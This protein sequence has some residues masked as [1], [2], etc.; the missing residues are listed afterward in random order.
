MV[1]AQA[2][3]EQA[4]YAVQHGLSQQRAC[5]LMRAARSGL[6]YDLRMPVKDVPVVE[7]MIDLSW[8]FPRFGARRINVFLSRQGMKISKD[9][10]WSAAG[11]QVPP[12]KKRGRDVARTSP[13]PMSPLGGN[14]VWCFDFVRAPLWPVEFS[15]TPGSF[16]Q[17]A[18]LRR[19]E[20]HSGSA[21]PAFNFCRLLAME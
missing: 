8:Q 12:R 20:L 18:R 2:R 1:N 19:R 9:R 14:L 3:L 15:S 21:R 6:Y 13:W 16:G 5:A 4:R 11:L 10:V 17:S 7:A